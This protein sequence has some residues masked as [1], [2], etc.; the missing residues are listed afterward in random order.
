MLTGLAKLVDMAPSTAE[1]RDAVLNGFHAS[2]KKTVPCKFFYDR[3]GSRL[4]EHIC[5]TPEYIIRHDR[6]GAG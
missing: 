6:V 5:E 2:R 1:F 4:F 3:V